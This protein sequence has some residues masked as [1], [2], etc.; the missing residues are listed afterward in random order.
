MGVHLEQSLVSLRGSLMANKRQ[1]CGKITLY[2]TGKLVC[3]HLFS[4]SVEA[5][6]TE[7]EY[8]TSLTTKLLTTCARH[9]AVTVECDWR[10]RDYI[11][12]GRKYSEKWSKNLFRNSQFFP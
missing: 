6:T 9:P 1:A 12:L 8:V 5:I 7:V 2:T 10:T 11:R 3:L 4:I